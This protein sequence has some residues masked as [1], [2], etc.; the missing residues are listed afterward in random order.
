MEFNKSQGLIIGTITSF[1]L[2]IP[3]INKI[4]TEEVIKIVM[5]NPTTQIIFLVS[6]IKI[7]LVIA[8]ITWLIQLI[9]NIELTHRTKNV[10]QFQNYMFTLLATG[11]LTFFIV[12]FVKSYFNI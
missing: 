5:K 9:K 4:F 1:M 8:S 3:D 11:F 2:G 6:L 12:L 10:Q 7:L